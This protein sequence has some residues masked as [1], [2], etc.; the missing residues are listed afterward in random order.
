M[1]NAKRNRGLALLAAVLASGVASVAAAQ[2][3]VE[4]AWARATV[5]GAKVGAA[6][7]TLTNT[8]A[9]ES[10]LL[11]IV[12]P[13]S[14]EVT[15]H[16]TSITNEGVARMWPLSGLELAGGE[17]LRM[18]QGGVHVMFNKLKKPLVA[19]EK[20]PLTMKFDGGQP[21]FTV[22]VEVRPLVEAAED[23]SHHHNH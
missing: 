17:T 9:D 15:L 18:D 19:G 13:V 10:K 4:E 8:G 1:N 6:Y 14:D 16:R 21:E 7:L 23:H 11:K 3:K 12:S 20:F 5:P 22:M 2:V